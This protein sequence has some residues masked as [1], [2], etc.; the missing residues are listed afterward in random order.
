MSSLTIEERIERDTC[1]VLLYGWVGQLESHGYATL[2]QVG[3]DVIAHCSPDVSDLF[4]V[5]FDEEALTPQLNVPQE[6]SQYFLAAPWKYAQFRNTD[7]HELFVDLVCGSADI[8]NSRLILRLPLLHAFGEFFTSLWLCLREF[9]EN[10][11]EEL[12]RSRYL[13]LSQV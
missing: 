12:P 9:V 10:P 1:T 6:L 7:T 2:E 5:S 8:D 4:A 13:M 3:D 11:A